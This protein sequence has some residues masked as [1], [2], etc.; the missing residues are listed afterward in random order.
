MQLFVVLL[1][2]T[3][4]IS[5]VIGYLHRNQLNKSKEAADLNS[6][7][8]P[9]SDDQVKAGTR[10]PI[11][12]VPALHTQEDKG[13]TWQDEVRQLRDSGQFMEAISLCK[14]QYPKILAF[15]QTLI[16]IRAQLKE[17]PSIT[18]EVLESLYKTAILGNWVKSDTSNPDTEM[19]HKLET[20]QNSRR[21]WETLGYKQLE[22]LTKTDCKFLVEHWGEP[23]AHNSINIFLDS[24]IQTNIRQ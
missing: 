22:Y 4:L 16:T 20:L 9:L 12:V 2:F 3:F 14:R 24:S 13:L 5:A 19:R 6:P 11:G 10:Q 8:P 1:I 17:D 18:E 7:L 15:R 21:Y 23:E